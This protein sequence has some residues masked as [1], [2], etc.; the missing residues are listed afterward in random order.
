MPLQS[1]ALILFILMYVVMIVKQE[2][3]LYAIW[4]VALLF[5]GLGILQRNPLYLLS[6]INWNVIMMIGGTMVIVYYFIESKMP[7]RLAEIILDKCPNVMWVIILMSLFAGSVSA[8]IDN[9]ATVLMIAPVG[10]AICKKIKISPVPMLLSIAVSSNLQGAAT[11]VGDTTSIM[12]GGYAKMNFMEFFF[13]KGKPG[14]F[15]SVELG[16]MATVPIMML[17]FRK[18]RQPVEATEKTEVEGYFPSIALIGV[19]VSL[20]VAS[21]IPNT[22]GIINGLICCVIAVICM[23]VDFHVKKMPE[24]LKKSL[25]SVDRETLMILMGLFLVIQG[26]TD[27]G[28]IDLAAEGIV[29]LGGNNLFLLYSIIVWGSVI[30]SAFID[31]IPYVA[32]MLPIITGICQLLQIEPYLLYFGLLTGAT[33]G[34]NITPIGASANITAVG[35]LKQ[36]G[37]KVGFDEFMKIG[38]PFTLAAAGTGYLFVW[39]IWR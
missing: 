16:A 15:F 1:I 3:R 39:F 7:N 38:I 21:F 35:M 26:I 11:L 29:K 2:W 31:N 17:L 9:V 33:L 4:A 36:E 30:F 28:L 23:A 27:V 12:L 14:M 37:Y 24:N 19:V 10:L 8:F 34:G 25:L 13:M 6:V 18:F 5:V 32:T 20:I 22:P